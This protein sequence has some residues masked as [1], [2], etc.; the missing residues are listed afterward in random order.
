MGEISDKE[1]LVNKLV[2][3]ERNEEALN[4]LYDMICECLKSGDFS[5]AEILRDR[6]YEID[7]MALNVIIKTNELIDNA[8]AEGINKSHKDVWKNFYGEL[9]PEEANAFFYE[10]KEEKFEIGQKVLSQGDISDSLYLVDSG[11][12]NV[13]MCVQGKETFLEGLEPGFFFGVESFF[14]DSVSTVSFAAGSNITLQRLGKE[15]LKKWE[16]EFP[17]LGNKLSEYCRKYKNL[18]DMLGGKDKDRRSDRRVSASGL[19][20]FQILN[21]EGRSV[22]GDFKGRLMNVSKGGL[23]FLIK[24]NK[25]TAHLL[26]G[27]NL[28]LDFLLLPGKLDRNVSEVGSVTAVQFLPLF[29]DSSNDFSIHMKC[30]LKLTDNELNEL[31]K[32]AAPDFK[33]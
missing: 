27:R 8:K 17:M 6:I 13:S 11:T 20:K 16:S 19:V 32:N 29:S 1:E 10:L 31:L 18:K 33:S 2:F 26:L 30:E 25:E 28:K 4:L 5:K 23:A 7:S 22:K 14:Y 24:T 12:I 9:S 15:V 21:S 3:Q